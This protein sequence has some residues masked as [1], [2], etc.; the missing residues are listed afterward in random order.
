MVETRSLLV[1]VDATS[2]QM[3][4]RGDP[5]NASPGPSDGK[6]HGRIGR[7]GPGP[8]RLSAVACR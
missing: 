8:D 4:G 3:D 6:G 7:R 2:L 1:M 5:L